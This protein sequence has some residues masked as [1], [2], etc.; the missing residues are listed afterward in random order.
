MKVRILVAVISS[1]ILIS[2]CSTKP[3]LAGAAAIVGDVKITQAT[4]TESVNAVFAQIEKLPASSTTQVPTAAQVTRTTVDR[5]VR[6]ELFRVATLTPKYAVS[7]AAIS[8][9]REDA[10][11]DY[12][13]ES[14]ESQLASNNGV[15]ANQIDLFIRNIL[16]QDA[17]IKDLSPTG[18]Q[19]EQTSA[20][21]SYLSGLSSELGVRIAPRYGEWSSERIQSIAGDRSLAVPLPV[22]VVE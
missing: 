17:I 10:F 18:T 3:N 12:G 1:A 6:D 5:L 7:Q 19:D 21:V 16:V 8:K 15:P 13:K 2:G 4:V 22:P 20:L 9:M 14:V 11:R